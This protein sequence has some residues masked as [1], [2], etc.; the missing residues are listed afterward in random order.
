MGELLVGLNGLDEGNL[1]RR[2]I[3][4]AAPKTS[5][6]APEGSGMRVISLIVTEK[7]KLRG[8]NLKPKVV[9]LLPPR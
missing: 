9:L 4:A 8:M 2:F 1:E 5:R 3:K 7:F 6:Q